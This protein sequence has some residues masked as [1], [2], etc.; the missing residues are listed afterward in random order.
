MLRTDENIKFC[1]GENTWKF[2]KFAVA[3]TRWCEVFSKHLSLILCHKIH[4]YV[5]GDITSKEDV[6]KIFISHQ[7]DVVFHSA[8]YGMSGREQVSMLYL[9]SEW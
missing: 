4:I 7:I 9:L 5:L 2:F 3:D 6:R 1:H 8:S